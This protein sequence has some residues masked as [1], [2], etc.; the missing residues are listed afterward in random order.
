MFAARVAGVS[1]G[2]L[3]RRLRQHLL[4]HGDDTDDSDLDLGDVPNSVAGLG[5]W[6]WELCGLLERQR[7]GPKTVYQ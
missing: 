1:A 7:L 4:G 2:L 3:V 5:R 6:S